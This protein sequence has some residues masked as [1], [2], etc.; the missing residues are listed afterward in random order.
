MDEEIE[1]SSIDQTMQETLAKI[2]GGGSSSDVAPPP[3]AAPR[4]TNQGAAAQ[5]AA[6]P[7]PVTATPEAWRQMPKSWR[8]EMGEV[9]GLQDPR[10]MQYIHEREEQVLRGIGQYKS[11][12]DQWS[13]T[14]K[15]YEQ[16][17]KQ[18]GINPHEFVGNLGAAHI[19]MKHGTAEQ[20]RAVAQMLDRDYGLSQFYAKG[21]DGQPVA[22]GPDMTPLNNRLATVETQLQQ[23]A[24]NDAVGEVEKFIA[25]PGNEFAKDAA[26][27]MLELLEANKVANLREAYDVAVRTDPALFERLVAKRIEAAT[28]T[29]AKPPTNVRSSGVKA[30]TA[31]NSRG[32]I[33]D[34][35]RVT[36]GDIQSR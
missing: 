35:M 4:I 34:T 9:W 19:L 13:N 5:Q 10:A 3:A 30:P 17:I 6:P 20:R 18:Y 32:T 27:R 16:Y 26:P 14:M 2:E 28:R 36:L 11:V 22:P 12:A 8:K 23:R 29:T 24:L 31:G 15:P 1:G 21:A 25:D 33:E 7:A